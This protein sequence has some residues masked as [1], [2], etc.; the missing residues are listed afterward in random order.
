M[1][2]GHHVSAV[3]VVCVCV[4]VVSNGRASNCVNHNEKNDHHDIQRIPYSTR[5][6]DALK[7][8]PCTNCRNGKSGSSRCSKHAIGFNATYSVIPIPNPGGCIRC[9]HNHMTME[10]CNNQTA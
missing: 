1:E 8:L 6:S 3:V 7:C 9:R 10:V 4:V 5:V 2:P